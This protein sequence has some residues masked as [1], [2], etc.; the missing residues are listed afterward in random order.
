M[1]FRNAVLSAALLA[2]LS[3]CAPSRRT[4]DF[5]P[6]WDEA[7]VLK[8]PGKGWYHHLLDNGVSK[9]AIRDDSLFRSFPGMDHLYLR[10]AWSYLEPREGA[11]DWSRI[12]SVIEKWTPLGYGI[13]F[14][15]TCKETGV[16][17]GSVG[18]KKDG[19][20]Y[21]TPHWVAGAGAR[22]VIA[23]NGGV[24]SWVPDWDDPVYLKKL[25]RFHRAF[26]D[27]YDGKPWVR[28]VDVG[29]IGEWGEGHTH[30]STK[31]PPGAAEVKAHIDVYAKNYKKTR[32]V[33]TDDLLYYGKSDA[34]AK[35][36]Y[37]YAV[38]K[39]LSLRDDSPL[40][41]WYVQEHLDTWSVSHPGFY[42]PLYLDRPV[43]FELEH[44]GAVKEDGNWRGK[45]GGDPIGPHG[46]SGAE[47]MRRAVETMHATFIG[48]HGYAEDWLAE[49]PDL[50]KEL[51]NRCGYWY[52]PKSARYAPVLHGGENRLSI[53]WLN[54]GVAPA[55]EVFGLEL[56][57]E[58]GGVPM[59]EISIK[60]SGNR[61]WLPGEPVT[62]G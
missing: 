13:A 42:D 24:R 12:D 58:G 17:P 38:S 61:K 16:Y 8:N 19:I 35:A 15:I 14:R 56:R 62:A 18:Q 4:V 25:D 53:E 31:I 46:H 59:V 7:R 36:L 5:R 48:Y 55:Y 43:V 39:G 33:C 51:A 57:L 54:R 3:S 41:S 60:D 52:F 49:N 37:D 6:K 47:I 20:Q 21:A 40:V 50:T 9:Y 27:R 30:F 2:A 11:F 22:G 44:Y 26:A 29:S 32:L 10:L 45:N 34:D 28:Y 23:E 1:R